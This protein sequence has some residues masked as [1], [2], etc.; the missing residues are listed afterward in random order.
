R[1][2]HRPCGPLWARRREGVLMRV[3]VCG[4]RTLTPPTSID[5]MLFGLTA[6]IGDDPEFVVI[7]GGARGADTL[8]RQWCENFGK[9]FEEYPA[10]WDRYGKRAGYIR[11]QQMLDEGKP[12]LVVAFYDGQERSR[13]TA[14]MCD[15]ARKAGIETWEVF[16]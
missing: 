1:R 5:V 16:S 11:N 3:L 12:D 10:D 9:D 15:L 2:G 4:S 8:A 14:M 13:G 6:V 7:E